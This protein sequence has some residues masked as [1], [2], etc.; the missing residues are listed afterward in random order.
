[1]VYNTNNRK[2]EVV[3]DS[4]AL[5]DFQKLSC[6]VKTDFQ[7]LIEILEEDG[8]LEYPESK[9][10]KSAAGLFEIRV[11]VQGQWRFLYAYLKQRCVVILHVFRKKTQK[12]PQREVRIALQRLKN[13]I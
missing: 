11:R 10:L 9:K 4:R 13:W 7:A 8:K 2:T 6:E 12:I 3:F 1:V 5:K